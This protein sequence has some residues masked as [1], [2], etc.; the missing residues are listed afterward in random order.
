MIGL[1]DIHG[2]QDDRIR[3]VKGVREYIFPYQVFLW[4]I[5]S[6]ITV[7]SLIPFPDLT[8]ISPPFCQ[9]FSG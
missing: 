4:A 1:R 2:F 7:I 6:T 9:C 8:D 3:Y 5:E